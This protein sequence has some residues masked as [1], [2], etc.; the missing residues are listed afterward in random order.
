MKLLRDLDVGEFTEKDYRICCEHTPGGKWFR[1]QVKLAH[2]LRLEDIKKTITAS[3]MRLEQVA[4]E[5]LSRD[6]VPEHVREY[7]LEH[8]A[9]KK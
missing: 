2:R 4:G 7:L 3:Y 9:Q 1:E 8:S 5:I 6:N